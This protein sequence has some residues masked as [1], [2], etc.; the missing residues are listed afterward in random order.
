MTC[1][2]GLSLACHLDSSFQIQFLSLGNPQKTY[3]AAGVSHRG[4]TCQCQARGGNVYSV[5][6]LGGTWPTWSEVQGS[7]MPCSADYSD[8]I[9]KIHKRQLLLEICVAGS[10]LLFQGFY[11]KK[12]FSGHCFHLFFLE[13]VDGQLTRV[14]GNQQFFVCNHSCRSFSAFSLSWF[15]KTNN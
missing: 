6:Q 7:C 2:R 12:Y 3:G 1:C 9:L 5:Q 15:A 11:F 8:W 10:L 4:K 14:W 13:L